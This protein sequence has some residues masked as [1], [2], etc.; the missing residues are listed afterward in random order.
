[1]IKSTAEVF[2]EAEVSDTPA[3]KL[4]VYEYAVVFDIFRMNPNSPISIT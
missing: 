3:L 2:Y 4:R 1:M